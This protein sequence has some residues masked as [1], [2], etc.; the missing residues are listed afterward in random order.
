MKTKT[1]SNRRAHAVW[2]VLKLA[3]AD[4]FLRLALAAAVL[5]G[6]AFA[7]GTITS[8]GKRLSRFQSYDP[9]TPP[10]LDLPNAYELAISRIGAA[11][12]RIHCVSATCLELTNNGFTGWTFWFSDTNSQRAR[13]DVFF[14]K[15]VYVGIPSDQVLRGK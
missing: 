1:I 12:N 4:R 11:S 9:K 13:I 6:L 14:D 8:G 10:P 2:D 7:Q 5:G 15:E 3:L